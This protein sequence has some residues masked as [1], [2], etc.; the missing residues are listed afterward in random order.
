[1][2]EKNSWAERGVGTFKLNVAHSASNADDL[3]AGVEAEK[4]KSRSQ[5]R[6][7]MRSMA[8]HKVLLNAPVFKDMRIG[9]AKGDEPNGKAI[10]FSAVVDGKL[11]PHTLRVSLS[12]LSYIT[13]S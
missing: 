3:E 8:T 2:P 4:D 12:R 10:Q 11:I 6:F 13:E 1:M 5:A 7:I 9:D